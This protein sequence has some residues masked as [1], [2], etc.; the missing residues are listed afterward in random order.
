MTLDKVNNRLFIGHHGNSRY[1][2]Y[3]LD[4]A[5][6]PARR[7][8]D[9]GIG[10]S[11][12]GRGF[13]FAPLGNTY[14]NFPANASF[15][16]STQRLFVPDNSSLGPPGYRI[17]VFD[18]DPE[19]LA[20]LERGELPQAIAVLGQ[21]NFNIWDPGAGPAKINGRGIAMVAPDRQLLFYADLFNNRVLVWD[22]HPDRFESG[23]D[24]M[25]VLGQPD[26]DSVESGIGPDRFTRPT[27][28]AY[29]PNEQSLFIMDGGNNRVLVFDASPE[30]LR[31]GISA[32]AVIGQE[33]FVSR[34]PRS[35]IRKIGMGP[36]SLDYQYHRLFVGE[37]FGNRMV[38]IDV[39]PDTLNGAL[40][41]DAIAVL[42][43]P[44]FESTEPVVSQTRLTMPR[45]TVDTER[46][47]AYIPDGYP[48]GNHI[49]I[50]D[51]HPD[52]LQSTS[53]PLLD[54]IGHI[55]PEGEPD[56][57]AR[58]ANDRVSPRYWTQAR[59]ISLDTVDHRLFV[60][61][62]YGHRVMIFQL[63]RMNRILERGA[64][65][66][67]GQ[68]DGDTSLLLPV[69]DATTIKLPLAVEYDESHKRLFVA[70]TW[71]DRVMVFDMTPG[72]V[73][74][75]ME[76]S[77]VLG[78]ADFESYDPRAAR[79]RIYFGSRAGAGIYTTQA[80]AA[81]LAMDEQNQRLFVMDGGNHRVLV[82]DVHPD[83][84]ESGAEAIAVLGQDDFTSSETGLSATRWELP[85]DLV[86]DEQNQRLFVGVAWQHRV[87][88]FDV[89]PD[90]LRNG[91]PASF[92]IGQED[93][94]SAEPG[95]SASRFRQTD[96]LSYDD[97]N[98]QLF[99]TDKYNHRVLVYAVPPGQT[100]S[101]PEAVAVLGEQ[102]FDK[103]EM[104]PG[105]PRN[106]PDRLYDPR[107]SVFDSADQ[108]LFQ[109][110][111][112]NGRLTVFTLPREDY[113]VDLPARSRLSYESLDAQLSTGPQPRAVGYSELELSGPTEIAA[114][115]THLIT[116]AV[117]DPDSE[118][119]SRV[120]E[121]EAVLAVRA[122]SETAMLYFDSR[123][124]VELE[125]ALVNGNA[126][127]A[128]LDFELLTTSGESFA[129]TRRLEGGAQLAIDAA[130]LF[131]DAGEAQGALSIEANRPIG[132][133]GMLHLDDGN[134]GTLL[135]PSPRATQS[136]NALLAER[137]VLPA[138]TTGA[139]Q[140]ISYVLLNPSTEPV[141]GTL[142]VDGQT[143]E[144]SILPGGVFVNET[145]GD[146]RPL[147]TGYGIIR[148]SEGQA[149]S[150]FALVM[151]ERRDRSLSSAHSVGSHQEGTLFWGPVDTYPSLLR[152]G[153]IEAELS[154]V[155]EGTVPATVYLELF[156]IDGKSS[157]KVEQIVPLGR[158]AQLSLE[159]AF[160]RS[161][162][163]GTLRVFSDVQVGATLQRK[164]KNVVGDIVVT[165]IPLQP[166]PE[167]PMDSIIFPLFADG[168]GSATELLMMNTGRT[169]Q[170]GSLR[171]R[172][173]SGEVQ[174]MILR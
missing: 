147:A 80:R 82:F 157:G 57:T 167:E 119:Q 31:S 52:R 12:I 64:R 99:V 110:E 122:P 54:Q 96:G 97:R 73:E 77:Y 35:D 86:L 143:T 37:A 26:F 170:E 81:E 19:K 164:V 125:L 72:Q 8:A 146:I 41:P 100:S 62:N 43:Q 2:V 133:A 45:I 173:Q 152:H 120:L 150:G 29:D 102:S 38:V 39:N 14:L 15:D 40:N 53:Q 17:M 168:S 117:M 161:P 104:G 27:F 116:R 101:L 158:R 135:V 60:S 131:P 71:S 42:G 106:Y 172:S 108:R 141:S 3:Q 165:D 162:L 23:M 84:I 78:Q 91:Q 144:Y 85:G 159:D 5:G 127:R 20:Q 1:D 56:F 4:D 24:A 59:D 46:Q 65:W 124:D 163:R 6:L 79:D 16:S 160:G 92:V 67:L 63:D 174:A 105:D 50:F 34:V 83:R 18:A 156:D 107:G 13:A 51:I 90:Q 112:L 95:L 128:D 169:D 44:D 114:V 145:G 123:A 10:R 103:V 11:L 25:L 139:G 132:V 142:E 109:S 36:M 94:T 171:V 148:A 58:S 136:D 151:T 69:R 32:F 76:A 134:G 7:N 93:F 137:R 9:Y 48:A 155:N 61:D 166:T 47:L 153:D 21:P 130:E 129:A 149:P 121:S 111:G 154:L 68:P 140:R 113:R 87:M 49:N 22:I 74:S 28:I 115:S 30:N 70:D 33:D 55:N 75:G 98:N 89:H 66:V 126:S 88:A 118:R 138:I